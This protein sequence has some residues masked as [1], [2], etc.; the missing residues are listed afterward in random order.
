MI[1]MQWLYLLAGAI[2]ASFGLASVRNATNPK[3][4]GNAAFWSL[5]AISFWFGDLLGD[6][7]NGVL[8]LAIV[9]LSGL[10]L[11]GRSPQEAT[12]T[13]EQRESFS[14]R[15]GNKLFLPALIIPFTAFLGTLLFNYTPL[16][17][18]GLIEPKSVTLVLLGVGVI[19]ALIVCYL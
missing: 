6:V 1:T 11:I 14:Q 12:T 3:R 18:S 16:K 7:A 10:H 8:V 4:W 13:V 5:L 15:Y 17:N 9:A 19:V 2:F